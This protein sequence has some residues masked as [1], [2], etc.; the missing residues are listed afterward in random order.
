MMRG[1]GVWLRGLAVHEVVEIRFGVLSDAR[2][3]QLTLI[4]ILTFTLCEPIHRLLL[5]ELS[6]FV[7]LVVFVETVLSSFAQKGIVGL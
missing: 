7:I 3:C 1:L 6:V 2:R 4:H 5:V